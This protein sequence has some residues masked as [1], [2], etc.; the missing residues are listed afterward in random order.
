MKKALIVGIDNYNSD[1][2]NLSSCINDAT[3]MAELLE[4]HENGEL[5]FE[6]KLE[7]DLQGISTLREHIKKCF[8]DGDCETALFYFSGHGS[9]NEFGGELILADYVK[10]N[11]GFSMNDI[12]TAV[13][14]SKAQ[15]KIVILDCC[16]AGYVGSLPTS[17]QAAVIENGVT[18]LTACKSEEYSLAGNKFSLFTSLLLE[19]LR[20]GAADIMGHI[21]L[22]GIYSYI[23][24]SL[25]SWGQRPLFKTNVS[26]FMS[27]RETTPHIDTKIIRNLTKYFAKP[28]ETLELDPSFEETNTLDTTHILAEPYANKENVKIFKELQKLES[29][30]LI[31]PTD[32]EHM[33]Y[34]AMESKGC[35]LT[36]LGQHYW[37]LVKN[38]KI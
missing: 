31:I 34:A 17:G 15:N 3:S 7:K 33:Y 16:H 30:G 8:N 38:K 2:L 37:T 26:R 27:L 36:L 32:T 10:S 1:R 12:L 5:N 9:I 22:G 29:I 21:T 20:G 35:K 13:N 25:G 23:D 6:V 11:I 19:A 14:N 4:R 18:I 24:K 28:N